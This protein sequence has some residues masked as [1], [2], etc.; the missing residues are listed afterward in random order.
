MSTTKNIVDSSL[1]YHQHT[2]AQF[3][4]VWFEHPLHKN[5]PINSLI[6]MNIAIIIVVM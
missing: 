2:D 4:E 6:V 5:L 1:D 3:F